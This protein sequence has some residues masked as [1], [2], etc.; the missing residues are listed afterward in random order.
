MVIHLFLNFLIIL[1]KKIYSRLQ[2][3]KHA[4]T[5]SIIIHE[6]EYLAGIEACKQNLHAF[7]T[8]LYVER[9]S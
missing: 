2:G 1:P 4:N 6:D 9:F 8:N 5:I 3:L 7:Q